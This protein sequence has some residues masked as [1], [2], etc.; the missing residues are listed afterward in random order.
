LASSSPGIKHK[1]KSRLV[2]QDLTAVGW[3]LDDQEAVGCVLWNK[4]VVL[5]DNLW[6]NSTHIEDDV[7]K[8]SEV[9]YEE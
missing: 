1:S 2:L 4:I 8:K 6:H 7:Q 5:C 3:A 9:L